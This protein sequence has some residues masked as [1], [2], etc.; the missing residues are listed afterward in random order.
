MRHNSFSN[1]A[2]SG[3]SGLAEDVAWPAMRGDDL[4]RPVLKQAG[5]PLP[6]NAARLM[7]T[8]LKPG[9]SVIVSFVGETKHRF[10]H[11]FADS[12]RRYDWHFLAGSIV[13]IFVR[14]GVDAG[15]AIDAIFRGCN[16]MLSYPAL[17]DIERRQVAYIVDGAR[18][19]L[20]LWRC[21]QESDL[22]LQHFAA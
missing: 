15:H 9:G 19:D 12:G 18:G 7:Q 4:L 2:M 17:V 13:A 5:L 11:V 20:K 6:R 3:V 14:P 16:P 1:R 8:G 21:T 10:P 22:W